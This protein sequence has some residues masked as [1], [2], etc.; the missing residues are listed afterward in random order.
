MAEDFH[1][2]KEKVWIYL[3]FIFQ[4]YYNIFAALPITRIFQC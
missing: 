2:M 4:L 3:Y 1:A